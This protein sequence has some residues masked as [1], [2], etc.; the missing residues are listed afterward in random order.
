[1]VDEDEKDYG[2]LVRNNMMRREDYAPYCGTDHCMGRAPF[3]GK[4]FQCTRCNWMSQFEPEFIEEY[5]AKWN[6]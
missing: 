6:K 3:N 1:M 4:Q 2:S 5:K